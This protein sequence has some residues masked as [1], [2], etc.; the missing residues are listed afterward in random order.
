ML[1]MTPLKPIASV[2]LIL[3]RQADG[4]RVL[5]TRRSEQLRE[6]PGEVA[7]PGGKRDQGD[8][9]FYRTALRE[10]EEEV[11]IAEHQLVYCAEMQ[12]QR[13][14]SGAGVIPF[15]AELRGQPEL[16]LCDAEIESARWVP[17]DLFLYDRRSVTHVFPLR[18]NR[19]AWAP[20][21][22]YEDYMVWGFTARVMVDFVNR[23][24][25]RQIQRSHDEAR[26]LVFRNL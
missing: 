4:D 19:E 11:G 26:E 13:T 15:V 6:H 23:F 5:L 2:L 7:L 20:V 9:S 25:G 16:Q 14:R 18:N 17:L 24:Y 10:C 12:P 3:S 1:K 8:T 22:H 21:Y